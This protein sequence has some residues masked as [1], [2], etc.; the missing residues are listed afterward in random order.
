MAESDSYVRMDHILLIHSS[1]D[2]L[3]GSFRLLAVVNYAAMNRCI[4]F[5]VCLFSVLWGV[6]IAVELQGQ[7]CVTFPSDLNVSMTGAMA[8]KLKEPSAFSLFRHNI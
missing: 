5:F 3:L 8:S 2:G 1:V 7:L 4:Y 6:H